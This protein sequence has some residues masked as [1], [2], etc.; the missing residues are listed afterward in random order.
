MRAKIILLIRIFLLLSGMFF[1][2]I[3]V[4]LWFFVEKNLYYSH[5]ISFANIVLGLVAWS[6]ATYRY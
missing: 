3:A 4:E 1:L 2:F 6:L 5:C